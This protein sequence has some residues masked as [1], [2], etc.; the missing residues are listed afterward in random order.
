M[1]HKSQ[2]EIM[3]PPLAFG[4]GSPTE[5]FVI[6]LV[7]LPTV[8]WIVELIDV[9]RRRFPDPSL[10]IVW[11]LVVIFTHFLG[12]LIYYVIGRKQGTLAA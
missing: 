3:Y 11:V 2:G 10:K 5:L 7:L 9:I 4:F 6:F 1:Q 12:A 8:F